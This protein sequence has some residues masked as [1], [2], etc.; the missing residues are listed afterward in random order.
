MPSVVSGYIWRFAEKENAS[1]LF[2][3]IRTWEQDGED[4]TSLHFSNLFFPMVLGPFVWPIP[5]HFLEARP[6]YKHISSSIIRKL[7]SECGDKTIDIS[8]LVP[9]ELNKE[10]ARLY[11]NS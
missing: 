5:T 1:I 10:I 11:A 3:G 8:H 4:E 2:R 9:K 7:C 6:E